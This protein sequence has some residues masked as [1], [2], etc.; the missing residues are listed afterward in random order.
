M[1]LLLLNKIKEK[2]KEFEELIEET[3][4]SSHR[5]KKYKDNIE[6]NKYAV[7]PNKLEDELRLIE[8]ME[9]NKRKMMDQKSPNGKF[10]NLLKKEPQKEEIKK[11]DDSLPKFGKSDNSA[12]N[13]Q[14]EFGN[15]FQKL[16][17]IKSKSPNFNERESSLP[18][19]EDLDDII[20]D[21]KNAK[22]NKFLGDSDLIDVKRNKSNNIIPKK[23]K[24]P[25][26]ELSKNKSFLGQSDNE[27]E[28]LD[29]FKQNITSTSF[30][31]NNSYHKSKKIDNK[32]KNK[33]EIM[34]LMDKI[35]NEL[36]KIEQDDNEL[37]VK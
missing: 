35:D 15:K 19:V 26:P 12:Y 8:E 23:E 27:D 14:P 9:F 37:P 18:K 10:A 6:E 4:E 29:A 24:F 20:S 5:H 13:N 32:A 36:N 21:N 28:V 22:I 31:M 33:D 3:K 25:K 17:E 1:T 11:Y 30:I 16:E 2:P 34:F 7:S